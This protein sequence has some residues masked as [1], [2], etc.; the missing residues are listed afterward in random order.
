MR[1][2][3]WFGWKTSD[4]GLTLPITALIS[5]RWRSA[6]PTSPVGSDLRIRANDSACA[7]S[8]SWQPGRPHH[9]RV[10]VVDGG[11]V[12]EVHPADGVDDLLDAAHPDLGVVVH[13]Q[14][15]QA[16]DRLDEQRRLSPRERGVELG[17][18][19]PGDLDVRVA[20]QRDQGG[21]TVLGDLE[22]QDRV[23]A[24][25]LGAVVAHRA[26]GAG[27]RAGQQVRGA[28]CVRRAAQR[29]RVLDLAVRP[30]RQPDRPREQGATSEHHDDKR[31]QRPPTAVRAVG[32][33]RRR[34]RS[35]RV[36]PARVGR[37]VVGRQGRDDVLRGPAVAG[38]IRP[39]PTPAV[40]DPRR[41]RPAATGRDGGRL[42]GT[43][44]GATSDRSAASA[45]WARTVRS[46]RASRTTGDRPRRPV[47]RRRTRRRTVR[48]VGPPA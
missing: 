18:V 46:R 41:A 22:Q 21:R 43:S 48:G 26:V 8:T 33:G 17:G 47:R 10:G 16:L 36:P 31:D 4:V 42:P 37:E 1:A 9:P 13:G 6:R 24:G 27:V 3:C 32:V 45:A 28:G 20:R 29:R 44:I 12:A 2:T 40:E 38:A 5:W 14:P 7:P 19:V 23:G 11:V 30:H 39:G 15:R 25:A 34:R 35:A